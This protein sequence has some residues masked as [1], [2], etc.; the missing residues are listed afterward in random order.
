[1]TEE[2]MGSI[3]EYSE[4]ISDATPPSSLPARDYPGEVIEADNGVSKNSGKRRAAV[5]F[6][7]RPDDFPADYTDAEDYPDGKLVTT[8]LS[9]ED[10]RPARWRMR[11]FCEA[12]GVTM[13]SSLDVNEFVGRK[14]LLSIEPDEYEGVPRERIRRVSAL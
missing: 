2:A 9:T 11:Q 14:A 7:I 1:M 4:D 8:Y 6:V 5:T 3:I 13:G 10:N 12:L